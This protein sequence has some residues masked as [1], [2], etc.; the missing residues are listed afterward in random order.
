MSPE[1]VTV[2]IQLGIAVG[3]GL[4][5]GLQRQH[6]ES[7]VAGLR[8]FPLITLAG[9]LTALIDQQHSAGGWIL[10]AGLIATAS[11]IVLGNLLKLRDTE[12]S[13]DA[14]LT[15]EA[16]ILLMFAVG[17]FL[18]KGESLVA[19]AVGATTAALLQFKP[20]LH[21][22]A[23][24][25]GDRDLRAIMQF[26]LFSCVILPVL[27]NRTYGPFEVL[28]PFHIWLMVVLI[29]GIS[30]S[31]YV[32]YR[33]FGESTGLVFGGVLGGAISSTATTVSYAK[34]AGRNPEACQSAAVVMMI[35]SSVV[36]IR[37]LIEISVVAPSHF[38]ELSQPL[39]V[40]L[41][42]SALTTAIAWIRTQREHGEMP[43]Q[44]NPTEFKS[45]IVFA[46]L[47]AVVLLALAGTKEWLGDMG[48]FAIAAVSGLND[49]D[50]ITLSTAGLVEKGAESGGL[51]AEAGW[52]LIVVATMST[53]LFKAGIAGVM[54]NRRLFLR[55]LGLF[56]VPMVTGAL[57]LW[58]WPDPAML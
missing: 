53:L 38:V 29:V 28:N 5:V 46:V 21:S 16:A 34:R 36:F 54:G 18:V 13:P 58:L 24:R 42:S 55:V 27:P 4:L 43:E 25:L 26:A 45:A 32:V 19:V 50:A 3:L 52:R 37:V 44:S 20:E 51:S 1:S 15:T 56:S 31:G 22:I 23:K 48:L 30:L 35:A 39:V 17:A 57:L 11:L 33:F 41:A 9:T 6:A 47:Y 40:M 8:T 10:A 2:F 14:G 7:R 12:R 49:M